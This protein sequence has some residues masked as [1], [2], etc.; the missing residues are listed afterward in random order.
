MHRLGHKNFYVQGGD[1]GHMVG[2]HM[3]TLFPKE[4]LG[5]H[6]NLPANFSKYAFL[7]W[8]L[9]SVWPSFVAGEHEDKMYPLADKIKFFL[10]EFG[11]M[12]LQITK[13]DTI[14][15]LICSN[16]KEQ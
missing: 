5:F 9:G 2:S 15:E 1:F 14:G 16:F 3:A 7:T 13:P 6:T 10:E 4:V 8:I 11:Y 12:H